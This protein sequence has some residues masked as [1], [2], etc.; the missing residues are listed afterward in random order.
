MKKFRLFLLLYILLSPFSGALAQSTIYTD[1]AQEAGDALMI[2]RGRKAIHY[3]FQFNGTFYWESPQFL[4]G[5]VVYNS[6]RYEGLLLNIDANLQQVQVKHPVSAI[7]VALNTSYL[8]S[9][10][11]GEKRFICR[12]GGIFEI[13]HNGPITLLRQITKKLN[14]DI[15][16][17]N[18]DAIGYYDPNFKENV[19]YYFKYN[20]TLYCLKDNDLILVKRE[21]DI[22]NLF[23]DR[24]KEIKAFVRKVSVSPRR[25]FEEYCVKVLDYAESTFK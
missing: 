13:L 17:R 4:V 11:I 9:F 12:D 22:L 15:H 25:N 21:K 2:Y 19:F 7:T 8:T 10:N 6:K 24:K 16:L 20:S 18:G 23:P 14:R 5:D 3:A 1:Y